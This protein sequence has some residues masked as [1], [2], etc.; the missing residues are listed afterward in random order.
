MDADDETGGKN[1]VKGGRNEAEGEN[2]NVVLPTG[3]SD[4]L[5]GNR[6]QREAVR[7]ND[8]IEGTHDSVTGQ[9]LTE[10]GWPAKNLELGVMETTGDN[11][12]KTACRPECGFPLPV[13]RRQICAGR[14]WQE[15]IGGTGN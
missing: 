3:G 8:A 10:T 1:G 14:R 4:D 5:D 6:T 13:T 9:D 2:V 11:K 7:H 12:G 15:E